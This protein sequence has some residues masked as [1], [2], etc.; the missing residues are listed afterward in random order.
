MGETITYNHALSGRRVAV[1]GA[2]GMLG[3]EL[4]RQLAETGAV[5]RLVVRNAARLEPLIR[6][7]GGSIEPDVFECELV[8]PEVLKDAF[9]GTDI[10]FHCAAQ[11]SFQ[12]DDDDQVRTNTDITHHVVG[13]CLEA[14]IGRLVHVSSI[15]ALG[16]PNERGLIDEGSYPDN[17]AGWNSYSLSKFYS[18]NEVW[19][20]IRYGLQATIVNPSVILGPGDWK[21][22]G[23]AAL[24]AALSGGIPFYVPGANGYVDV[25]D[26]AAAMISLSTS[27]GAVNKRFL[28]NGANLSYKELITL[29]S[30]STGKRPPRWAVGER[31]LNRAWR[32]TGWWAK[33][34]R[35]KPLLS[36]SLVRAALAANYYDGEAVKKAIGFEYRPIV[37]TMQYLASAYLSDKKQEKVIKSNKKRS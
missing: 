8:N 34:T 27:A 37:Q 12:S 36:E 20:G 1:T 17:L 35:S 10:V 11:V 30:R 33:M 2:S 14:G 13:A 7:L 19:R 3:S 18:E 26:V 22:R 32:I 4:V 23:S 25:R 24:F 31:G 29:A 6:S 21:G 9:A 15:A 5:V 28:L 16:E